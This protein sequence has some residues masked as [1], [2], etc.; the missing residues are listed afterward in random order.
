MIKILALLVALSTSAA[1]A[2]AP[3][4]AADINPLSAN[5][6]KT[7]FQKNAAPDFWALIPYYIPQDTGRGCS[8]AN[9]AMILNGARVGMPLTASD[10]LIT[11][12]NF[13]ENYA[14]KTYAKT[15]KGKGLLTGTVFA[16]TNLA[17]VLK[18]AA[19][20]LKI[21][22]AASSIEFVEID[23]KNLTTGR[24]R[25]TEALKRNEKSANDFI[26]FSFVQGKAT[27]DP[28]GGAHVATVGAFDES[29]DQVLVLDPDRQYYEPYWISA[30]KLF[31]AIRDPASD[32][33]KKVGWIHFKVRD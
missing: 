6:N 30:D 5:S 32:S 31:E 26:F 1:A 25:F 10:E 11:F 28:E 2:A 29:K 9:I 27:G 16:N 7:Y 12:K 3:K 13:L 19:E 24:A 15:I 20:K 23:Q 8:A 21:T 33:E 18:S 4:Y 22:T 17:K 14:D